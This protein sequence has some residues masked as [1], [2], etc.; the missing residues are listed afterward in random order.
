MSRLGDFFSDPLL[1]SEKRRKYPLF[2][3]IAA[4][5]TWIMLLIQE[6]VNPYMKESVTAT[7][8]GYAALA[9]S[10]SAAGVVVGTLGMSVY[11]WGRWLIQRCPDDEHDA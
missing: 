9:V 2:L 8:V 10:L 7:V 4:I 11:L 3:I 5:T 6:D 1:N